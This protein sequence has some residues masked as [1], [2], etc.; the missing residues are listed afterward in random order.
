MDNT[1]KHNSTIIDKLSKILLKKNIDI[2]QEEWEGEVNKKCEWVSNNIDV[3]R[4][5]QEDK[6][7]YPLCLRREQNSFINELILFIYHNKIP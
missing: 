3:Y 6:F 2:F 1:I 4:F 7:S 5:G